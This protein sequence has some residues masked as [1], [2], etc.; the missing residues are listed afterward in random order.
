[1]DN[2]SVSQK[3]VFQQ[4]NVLFILSLILCC[5]GI[6][7]LT[8]YLAVLWIRTHFFRIRIRI[9]KLFFSDSDSD[10]DLDS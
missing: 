8:Q 10:T 4:Q 3:K 2:C 6:S 9:H 5:T 7:Y 1:M